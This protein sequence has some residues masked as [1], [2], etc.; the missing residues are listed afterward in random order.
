M[1]TQLPSEATSEQEI[2]KQIQEKLSSW[3]KSAQ[4]HGDPRLSRHHDG[5]VLHKAFGIPPLHRYMEKARRHDKFVARF[6]KPFLGTIVHTWDRDRELLESI[7]DRYGE[8]GDLEYDPDERL[9]ASCVLQDE[10]EPM[11]QK[12]LE[13]ILE[14]DYL[15]ILGD[16]GTDVQAYGPP[17]SG[18]TTLGLALSMW[19]MQANNET[20]L[21]A[22]T[23]DDSGVNDRTEW[24][25]MA[26]W[27]TLALPEGYDVRV[28]AVPRN[29]SVSAFE[30]DV[31]QICRDVIRYSSPRDLNQQLMEGQ[32]YVVYPDPS[33]SG[34]SEVSRH[35]FVTD[36]DV[37]PVGEDGPDS[38]T[39]IDHWWFSFY[40]ARI[41][42]DDFVHFTTVSMDEAGN[43]LDPDAQK[44]VHE[45]YQKIKWLVRKF[46]DARKK[47]LTLDTFSH[48]ISELNTH[49]RKKQRWWCTMNGAAPPLNKKL[50]GDKRCPI[51]HDWTSDMDT[52][53]GQFWTTQ[54]YCSVAWPDL[55]REG[56]IDAQISIEFPEVGGW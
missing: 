22:D 30:I 55:K 48:A 44:D 41:T 21:W 6:P 32:F 15:D 31:D 23:L 45:T 39:P 34:C 47:G 27:A 4:A 19:R 17:D 10:Y 12:T 5:E 37:T 16:G 43:F 46:A 42:H 40:A 51:N 36:A 54:N 50:P 8:D 35:K 1:S 14:Y 2:R 20:V 9:A 18:K 29:P 25:A 33:F 3:E 53:E 52:G 7:E 13:W 24:L 56:R 26:P 11:R 28:R 49:F 38:R